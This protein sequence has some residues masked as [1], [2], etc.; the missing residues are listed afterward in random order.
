MAHSKNQFLIF[1]STF[2]QKI[3]HLKTLGHKIKIIEQ[4]NYW[5]YANIDEL[6]E[7]SKNGFLKQA[8]EKQL[9]SINMKHKFGNMTFDE[10]A[11][12]EFK[13]QLQDISEE[14]IR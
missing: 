3:N 6:Y 11:K 5:L 10:A 2:G 14:L 8:S 13:T 12:L 9:M 4:V 1:K 7:K